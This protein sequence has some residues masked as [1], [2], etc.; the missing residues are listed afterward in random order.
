MKN[1]YTWFILLLVIFVTFLFSTTSYTEEGEPSELSKIVTLR[2]LEESES[3]A[4]KREEYSICPKT[5]MKNKCFHCHTAPTFA[6]KVA[7]PHVIYDYPTLQKFRFIF[8]KEG[9][10]NK[11]YFVLKDIDAEDLQVVMQYCDQHSIDYLIVELFS[12]GG[13]LLDAYK[14]V[15]LIRNWQAEGKI[16]ETRCYGFAASAG[17]L[18]FAS[19]D[20]GLRFV[21]PQ[22][23]LMWHELQALE[24]F[25][26]A[27]PSDKEDEAKVLRH[28]QDTANSWLAEVSG[29]TKE[30]IDNL[31][32]KK[33]YWINGKEAIEAGFADSLLSK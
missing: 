10:P 19:G 18:V 8:D 32:R 7:D 5:K 33:E 23:E 15:G 25:N 26:I 2:G 9:N 12:P 31:V 24:L 22:A 27:S 30:E 13:S 28:L 16:F 20:K 3:D 6:L 1:R 4:D 21:S 29:K 11:A 14:M 17:F